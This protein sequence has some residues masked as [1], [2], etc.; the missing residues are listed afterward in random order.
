VLGQL[1]VA[2]QEAEACSR[3]SRRA[4]QSASVAIEWQATINCGSDVRA[5]CRG[6]VQC[7]LSPA[8]VAAWLTTRPS[9]RRWPS[10][11][12]RASTV[13]GSAEQAAG[14]AS[15]WRCHR[16]RRRWLCDTPCW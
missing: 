4:S 11:G 13:L 7:H 15:S 9:V 3:R 10:A 1:L 6:R 12:S 16:S 8:A 2:V 5:I 14:W